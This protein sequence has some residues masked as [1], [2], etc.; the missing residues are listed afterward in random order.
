MVSFVDIMEASEKPFTYDIPWLHQSSMNW[1]DTT[2]APIKKDSKAFFQKF[3]KCNSNSA[4]KF[5]MYK[6][7]QH[8]M[9]SDEMYSDPLFW[10]IT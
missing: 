10:M 9:F 6:T 1:H 4:V 7:M 8:D 2:L 3:A 5:S